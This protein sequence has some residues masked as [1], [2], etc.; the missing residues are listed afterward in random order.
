MLSP[1]DDTA[2]V[3]VTML[4]PGRST[5]QQAAVT[6]TCVSS[7]PK[8]NDMQVGRGD[9]P[10]WDLRVMGGVNWVARIKVYSVHA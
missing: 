9:S 4:R 2:M 5:L 3:M 7:G 6:G 10:G 8:G 1:A